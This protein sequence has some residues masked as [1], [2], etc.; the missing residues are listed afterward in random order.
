MALPTLM[1]APNGARLGKSDHPGLP[2][3]LEE[4]CSTAKACFAAGARGLH[5]HLRDKDGRHVLDAGYYREAL[6]EL[7]LRVPGMA[8]QVTTEA[9][10]LYAPPQQRKV[11][12]ACGARSVSVAVS[13]MLAGVDDT[14][15]RDFY[16][17]CAERG[18]EVQHI[19]YQP[20]DLHRL[21]RLLP[22]DDPALQ[23]LFVLGRYGAG[24]AQGPGA[25][26]PFLAGL[27]HQQISPDWAACAFGRQETSSLMAAHMAGGKLRVGFENSFWNLDGSR[28]E[29]NAERVAEI[30]AM[31]RG[32][33][34]PDPKSADGR[35]APL[36]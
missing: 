30:A 5:L 25:L 3:T 19:L 29:S 6:S 35:Q 18:I 23:L 33:Q 1:V 20:E 21:A 13:E 22:L 7:G 12:L 36:H 10:G 17:A 26:L 15:A 31:T 28:A 8:V 2:L 34:P 14:V 16:A 27:A 32:I 11:A 9:A 24:G 4:I